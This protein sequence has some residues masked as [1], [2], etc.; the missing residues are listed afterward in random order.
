MC[1]RYDL[2]VTLTIEDK[3]PRAMIK[4]LLKASKGGK[5]EDMVL[6]MDASMAVSWGYGSEKFY[7]YSRLPLGDFGILH[8]R[9]W[10]DRP[11]CIHVT[12]SAL[13]LSGANNWW[14]AH[15]RGLFFTEVCHD[16]H[17]DSLNAINMADLSTSLTLLTAV[18]SIL[19]G[20]LNSV[21]HQY[22][23]TCQK[24]NDSRMTPTR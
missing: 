6:S 16:I 5:K 3:D 24:A 11:S 14:I 12:D 19:L 23:H 1:D 18:S 9:K 10:Q 8:P 21:L 7:V 15:F 22:N 17:N 20:S 2:W 4:S 13:P